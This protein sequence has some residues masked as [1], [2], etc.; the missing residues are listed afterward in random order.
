M[1]FN[2]YMHVY[3]KSLLMRFAPTAVVQE[4]RAELY[5]ENLA[6]CRRETLNAVAEIHHRVGYLSVLFGCGCG[7]GVS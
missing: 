6:K 4:E 2:S 1:V 5:H 7:L 3:G